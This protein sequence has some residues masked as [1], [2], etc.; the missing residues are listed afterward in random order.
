MLKTKLRFSFKI[1]VVVDLFKSK[2][3]SS[4]IEMEICESLMIKRNI[5]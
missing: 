4:F 2:L 1:I 3:N 5:N